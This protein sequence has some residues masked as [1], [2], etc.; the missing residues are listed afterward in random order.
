VCSFCVLQPSVDSKGY[1]VLANMA[2]KI[3]RTIIVS[4]LVQAFTCKMIMFID[5]GCFSPHLLT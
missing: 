2:W 4:L 1:S 5:S 3:I